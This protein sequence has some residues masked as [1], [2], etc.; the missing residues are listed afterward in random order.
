M[1]DK[2]LTEF[3]QKHIHPEACVC[4]GKPTSKRKCGC[5]FEALS[6]KDGI[7][8][9]DETC[10]CVRKGSGA[11][12]SVPV[13]LENEACL[14]AKNLLT[15]AADRSDAMKNYALRS[16]LEDKLQEQIFDAY[17]ASLGFC[18]DSAVAL[19]YISAAKARSKEICR[20]IEEAF[21]PG[22]EVLTLEVDSNT[23]VMVKIL[24][25]ETR[26][27]IADIAGAVIA[28]SIDEADTAVCVGVSIKNSY[29]EL[30]S[31]YTEAVKA[32][33]LG[34]KRFPGHMLFFYSDFVLYE[35]LNELPDGALKVFRD[36]IIGT[37][38]NAVLDREMLLTVKAL[39]E[40][41]LNISSA[42]RALFVHR[43]SLLYRIDKLQNMTGLDI[44]KFEDAVMLRLLLSDE[45]ADISN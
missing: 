36:K 29:K 11:M 28:T 18:G 4:I 37:A 35:L 24:N 39:F 6:S 22:E 10:I 44:R 43:N 45:L 40:H 17:A 27:D 5:C 7:C 41:N 15:I 14:N 2:A 3:V 16:V 31:A 38:A 19:L 12:L 26:E 33:R 21:L 30:N 42:S 34:K 13:R 32:L 20:L 1:K 25:G 23:A 9:G 8:V